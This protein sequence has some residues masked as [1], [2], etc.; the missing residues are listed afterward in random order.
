MM[1]MEATR[2]TKTSVN[3]LPDCTAVSN[4]HEGKLEFT[5]E[6]TEISWIFA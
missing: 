5:L 6:G 2:S 4:I 1:K 3:L